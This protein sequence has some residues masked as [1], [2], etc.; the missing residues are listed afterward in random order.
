MSRT[1]IHSSVLFIALG[2]ELL[3]FQL[4][5]PLRAIADEGIGLGGLTKVPSC[6]VVAGGVLEM[7]A[8]V[9]NRTDEVWS[10]LIVTKIQGYESRQGI[11]KV[12]VA[13]NENKIVRFGI[14]VPESFQPRQFVNVTT[15]LKQPIG[16]TEVIMSR[17]G[18]P[19]SESNRFE[20]LPAQTWNATAMD[21]PPPIYPFWY[22]PK[23]P[24]DELPSLELAMAVQ[25]DAGYSRHTASFDR[26]ALPLNQRAWSEIDMLVLSD[27]RI[28]RETASVDALRN[29][30]HRGGR[31]WVML[32][33]VPCELIRPL[34]EGDMTCELV[35]TVELQDFTVELSSSD[36]RLAEEDRTVHLD[37]PAS[38]SRVLL[39]GARVTHRVDGWPAEFRMQIGHGELLATTLGSYAWLTPRDQ[40]T[41]SNDPLYQSKFSLHTWANLLGAQLID[42]RSQPPLSDT[43]VE[44]AGAQI[45]APLIPK[46]WI[47]LG[48]GSF[49]ALLGLT[50][51]WRWLA[52]D[53][54]W[55]GF[56]VP[57]LSFLV[58]G[59]M[60]LGRGMMSRGVEESRATF[61]Y[62][63]V[64]R[65]GNL[66]WVQEQSAMY[67]NTVQPMTLRGDTDGWAR[68]AS[69]VD[70]GVH[71]YVLSD[72]ENWELDNMAWPP[73]AWR[74]STSFAR[75]T[76]G[77]IASASLDREGCRLLLP[78]T[79][80]ESLE[81][82]VLSYVPGTPLL[83]QSDDATL[84]SDGSVKVGGE[85]WISGTLITDEQRRRM[86]VYRQLFSRDSGNTPAA[87]TLFGW[88]KIWEGPNWDRDVP[89]QGAALVGMPVQL[90][91]PAV[92]ELV[93]V[94]YGLIRL[95][96]STR[97]A[98]SSSAFN[99]GKGIWLPEITNGIDRNFEFVL[100][101]AL[102]PFTAE[103]LTLEFDIE[104]PQREV[105]IA[106]RT[107]VGEIDLVNQKAPSLPGRIEI[108]NPEVLS[109]VTDGVLEFRFVVSDRFNA[110]TSSKVVPWSV[111]YLHLSATGRVSE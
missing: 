93:A 59:V 111:G 73:D 105:R 30:L 26:P 11:R 109:T 41:Q 5:Y 85:R 12:T 89:F 79:M 21:D 40:Q 52:G 22:W 66:A 72:L 53:L 106:A 102:R 107:D 13:A 2:L 78:E 8:V 24:S 80:Q 103:S 69:N 88:T 77:F 46:S 48:L 99:D 64:R 70:S 76:D 95:R 110:S 92:G 39:T 96:Q 71:R 55:I 3:L 63:E 51:V 37:R 25:I 61:Q 47:V 42:E 60:L 36:L 58:G 31:V 101:K 9:A 87:E 86:D 57:T 28:L 34:L 97:Q 67:L 10:G 15:E 23:P 17:D 108:T 19:A 84:F 1:P 33:V 44:Y 45:G 18:K 68:A 38:M 82:A 65:D 50:G 32:D 75:E 20:V 14:D 29:Y 54:S 100:P 81:D 94:P 91:R 74:Y 27:E 6:R 90:A 62:A 43:D 56:L 98:G 16:N 83:V 7:R 49:C 35:D 104:A 4:A